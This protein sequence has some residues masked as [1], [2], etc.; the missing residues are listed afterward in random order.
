MCLN[1]VNGWLV[2][3]LLLAEQD[4]ATAK[5]IT[6]RLRLQQQASHSIRDTAI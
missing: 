2:S 1:S 5:K 3:L 6:V 4:F